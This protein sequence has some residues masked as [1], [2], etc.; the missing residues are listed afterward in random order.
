MRYRVSSGGVGR[1][2]RER[3]YKLLIPDDYAQKPTEKL[4]ET[5]VLFID[6]MGLTEKLTEK[7][8]I[9]NPGSVFMSF[10]EFL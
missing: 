5:Q 9:T 8:K 2:Y 1:K 3:S 4:K 6:S 10:S 7:L